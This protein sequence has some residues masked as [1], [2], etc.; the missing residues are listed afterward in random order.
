MI[1]K[2]SSVMGRPKELLGEY[3]RGE[4]MSIQAIKSKYGYEIAL[5]FKDGG[6]VIV[7]ADRYQKKQVAQFVSIMQ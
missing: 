2:T 1:Y 7:E 5:T 6:Y 3:D 4:L